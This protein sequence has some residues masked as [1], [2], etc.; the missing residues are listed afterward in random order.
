M[1][2]L[3]IAQE[4]NNEMYFLT[5]TVKHWYYIFDRHDRWD[6][7]LQSLKYCQKEK[8]LKVYSFVFMLNHIHLIVKSPDVSGFL[9]DFKKHTSREIMQNIRATEPMVVKLFEDEERK[10][11]LW[12][13]T[14]MPKIIQTESFFF[15]KKQYIEN[16]PVRKKYV[17]SPEHWIYSSAFSPALISLERAT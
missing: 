9:R 15:Q 5:L 1:P 2:S 13:K 16:N 17:T 6:I 11:S 7:L 12:Q 14:N 10:Y 8:N 4:L 3:R